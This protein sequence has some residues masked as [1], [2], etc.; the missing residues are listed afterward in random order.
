MAIESII[1]WADEESVICQCLKMASY[2]IDKCQFAYKRSF[3]GTMDGSVPNL[4][5]RK[6]VKVS[7]RQ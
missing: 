2:L 5:Y 7:K 1:V 3:I 4:I 6:L